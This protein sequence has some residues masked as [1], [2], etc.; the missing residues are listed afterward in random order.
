MGK[1]GICFV[2]PAPLVEP[3][4]TTALAKRC[5]EIGLDSFWVIDRI[6]YDNL[7]PLAVI[8]AAAAVTKRIRLGTSVLLAGLRHPT[9]L[10]KTIAT[11][12]FLSRGRVTLGIGFGSREND[13]T[14]VEIPFK[15]RGAR[16][17]EA[18]KLLR[19]LWSEEHVTFQGRFFHVENLT[20]GPKPIQSRLP[21][22]MGGGAD[23]VL[24]RVA[25][26]ADG[27]VCGSS[28]IQELP[29]LWGKICAFAS[30]AGRKPQE[31]EKAALTF[32]AI[33]EDK[34]RAVEACATYLKRYYGRVRMEIEKHLLV[35]AP[36][37][38]AERIASYF[39]K[40][41]DTLIIGTVTADLQQLD[42]FGEKVLPL[43]K[44]SNSS[45]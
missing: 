22:W 34:A 10:A 26:M 44:L 37:A 15:H 19:R 21:I 3:G 16:A 41:L 23:I 42:L 25:R 43:L 9:L 24:K 1:I 38:C 17:E 8:A 5:E 33:D 7:E 45:A 32:M 35:G 27:Y 18:V 39:Q 14:A 12:D 40:G 4:Y 11:L 31:I 28:A 6:A 13:F 36:T 20:L 29:S 30:A 2:N